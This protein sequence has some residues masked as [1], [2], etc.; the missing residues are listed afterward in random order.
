M[1][2]SDNTE[3]LEMGRKFLAGLK[4]TGPVAIEF[5]RDAQGQ[6]WLIE[7]NV[8]RTEYCVDLLIQSGLNLP[9]LE[10][11]DAVGIVGPKFT[12]TDLK[13]VVWYDTEKSPLCYLGDRW[14]RRT[15]TGRPVFPYL[16][17]RDWKPFAV[18][19]W[20]LSKELSGKAMR[21]LIP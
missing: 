9:L 12:G 3:V 10:Y 15:R 21:R 17:H 5:K 4:L 13:Q 7:P 8:G 6:Y 19:L 2:G 14:H 18:S 20:Q 11:N 1:S 16:G